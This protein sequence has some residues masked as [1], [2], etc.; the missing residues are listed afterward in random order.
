VRRYRYST[1]GKP[2]YSLP[3]DLQL[4]V[5]MTIDNDGFIH[6]I[7]VHT[8]R[9]DKTSTNTLVLGAAAA[10]ISGA[11]IHYELI[12]L[13]VTSWDGGVIQCN[14]CGSCC[15]ADFPYRFTSTSDKTELVITRNGK[16]YTMTKVGTITRN[17]NN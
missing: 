17:N 12:D 10:A 9:S 13:A 14:G 6:Y 8:S 5:R 1:G 16:D 7:A 4:G 3:N 2:F 15:R 11:G